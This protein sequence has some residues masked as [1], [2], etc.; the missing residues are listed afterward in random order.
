VLLRRVNV[1]GFARGRSFALGIFRANF[2]HFPM[3]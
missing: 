1:K 2:K 3:S